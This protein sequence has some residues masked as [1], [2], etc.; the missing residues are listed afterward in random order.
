MLDTIILEFSEKEFNI[1]DSSRFTIAPEQLR[2]ARGFAKSYNNPTASEKEQGLYKPR[3]TLFK[4]NYDLFLKVEFSAPKLLFYNNLDELEEYQF[5]IVVDRL[6][7]ELV[8]MGVRISKQAIEI[9]KVLH[10]HPSKN[11]P[12]TGGYTATFAI[13]ELL[14]IN[15]SK[16]FDLQEVKYRNDGHL[17]Q[18]YSGI[19][20]VA[21]YD[22][23][24]DM[25]K[26]EKRAVDKVQTSQQTTIFHEIKE[27]K[28]KVEVL[29]FEVRLTNKRKMNK[30]LEEIGY[31]PNPSF[32]DI[33]KKDVCQKIVNLY[34]E[35]FWG[36]ESWF[37][38]EVNNNPQD[39]LQKL[40]LNDPKIEGK[41]AIYLVGLNSLSRDDSGIRGFREI[42][43]GSRER[44][45]WANITR[46]LKK[47]E[48]PRFS[49]GLHGFIEDIRKNLKE[50]KAF[51]YE[52]GPE[53]VHLPCKAL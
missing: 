31:P 45:K 42:L 24:N 36:S 3:L 28:K 50:F 4:R 29:R 10:F 41:Q 19:H 53:T 2:L 40:F 35:M 12:L 34:W 1:F 30:V 8:S 46:D 22:K 32:K 11:I 7:T 51:R 44:T 38:F 20:S 9:A 14:K 16:K 33:F 43:C 26:P 25:G 23:I 49:Q 27:D 47:F 5:S 17:L 6:Q 37:L 15:L 39:L 52:N 18:I 13:R 48:G 21:L